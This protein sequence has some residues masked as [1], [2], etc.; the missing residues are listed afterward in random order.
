MK[1]LYRFRLGCVVLLIVS[2][3]AVYLEIYVWDIGSMARL[4][5]WAHAAVAALVGNAVAACVAWWQALEQR[6]Q[7][8]KP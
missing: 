3:I 5:F 1:N 2:V 7:Q 4:Y 6:K 8:R